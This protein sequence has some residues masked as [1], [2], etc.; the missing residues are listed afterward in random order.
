MKDCGKLDEKI[1]AVP[2]G[3]PTFKT[4]DEIGHLPR[5][6][7]DEMSHFFSVY[8]ML[9]GKETVVNEVEGRDKAIEIINHCLDSYIKNF[10]M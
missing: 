3:D 6:Y 7:F 8:K 9:E 1:I 10:C 2:F 4:I 5:H